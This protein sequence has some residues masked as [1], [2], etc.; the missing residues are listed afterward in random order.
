M[1]EYKSLPAV[2]YKAAGDSDR[3]RT[4]IAAVF[5]NIDAGSDITHLGAFTKTLSEGRQRHKHLWNHNSNNP[6][7]AKVDGIKEIGRSELPEEI[8]KYA[9]EAT[10][11]LWVKRTY[12]SIPEADW[13]LAAIDADAVNEMSYA[14]DVI[15][16][17]WSEV[18]GKR[19]RHLRELAL[20]DTSDVNYGMNPATLA[21]GAKNLFSIMP[22]GAVLQQLQL[23]EAE[24]KAGRR[25][26][27]SDQILINALHDIAMSLGCDSCKPDEEEKAEAA[28]TSTSLDFLSLQKRRL[29]LT[30]T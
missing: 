11:G 22:L 5:G 23:L 17:D 3:T 26:S 21:A 2:N 28:Q 24:V 19:V 10:G 1:A 15:K 27:G 29:E 12:L 18:D 16:S 6:P 14:Y 30:A 13:V 25:N 4:G 20:A 7:I 8:L 9:P